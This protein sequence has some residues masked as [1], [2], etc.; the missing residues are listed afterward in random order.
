MPFGKGDTGNGIASIAFDSTTDASGVA[1]VIGATDT[2]K[3]TMTDGSW[4]TYEVVNGAALGEVANTAYEGNKGKAVTDALAT[5]TADTANPHSVTKDQVGLGL[6][7]NTADAD[8]PISTATQS[9]LDAKLDDSQ[10]D[11]TVTLGTDNTKIPSQNAVKVYADTKV[12]HYTQDADP[13]VTNVK[14]GDT[15]WSTTDSKMYKCVAA[16]DGS[17]KQWLEI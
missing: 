11:T 7:D 3:L 6:V 5:H 1:G 2:Y 15:W 4:F 17:N 8:K 10:L 14:S 9:A 16:S 12:L 13:G